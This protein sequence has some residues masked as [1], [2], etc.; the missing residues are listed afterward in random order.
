MAY[1][2]NEKDESL[3]R[4]VDELKSGNPENVN[5]VYELSEK[6]IYKIIYD[7]VKDHYTTED[8]LQETYSQV[9]NNIA[10]LQD[11][12][13]FYM[14]AGRIASNITLRYI[15]K[16]RNEVLAEADK[17]GAPDFAFENAYQDTESFIPETILM[18]REKQRF[19][20]ETMDNLSVE[21]K[22]C[23]QFFY[24]EDLSV[25]EI[26]QEMNCSEH[27]VRSH[28][29]CARNAIKDAVINVDVKDDTKF[30][31]L[32]SLPLLWLLFRQSVEYFVIP[33][34][35]TADESVDTAAGGGFG[36]KAAIVVVA[37]LLIIGLGA[38]CGINYLRNKEPSA[39][40]QAADSQETPEVVE[41]E[42]AVY[43]VSAE[44]SQAAN[45]VIYAINAYIN[46]SEPFTGLA[47]RMISSEYLTYEQEADY[48]FRF[49][50]FLD[51]YCTA[52]WG[53]GFKK[54]YADGDIDDRS[55][56][57]DLLQL[58]AG[59][60]RHKGKL[61]DAAIF[62]AEYVSVYNSILVSGQE[63]YLLLPDGN[64]G[65]RNKYNQY[66]KYGFLVAAGLTNEHP[67]LF[68]YNDKGRVVAAR[69]DQVDFSFVYTYG[70]DGRITHGEGKT[71]KGRTT[72]DYT[73][74]EDSFEVKVNQLDADNVE[75]NSY[76]LGEFGIIPNDFE[77]AAIKML[78][79]YLEKY[80]LLRN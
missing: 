28:L 61:D 77:D 39:I 66:D 2:I 33:A 5:L 37:V 25:K 70:A 23:I 43:E 42:P 75:A 12:R 79:E 40:E 80:W 58:K 64:D 49:E 21:Q 62:F 56:L 29:S 36:A 4:A 54:V 22:L 7:I 6:Y 34:K 50:Q 71:Q 14:W 60:E 13:A 45:Q 8:L 68:E 9:Y 41:T 20:S 74:N 24:Y 46:C 47:T 78:P 38:Y 59:I 3:F 72:I 65:F 57:R 48:M 11:S 18:N 76:T 35:E 27:M 55:M 19:I 31:S 17:D 1:T 16:N 32:A 63:E 69:Y 73:W 10:S 15:Q 53:D 26:A 52:R 30:Y 67:E 44:L 51:D